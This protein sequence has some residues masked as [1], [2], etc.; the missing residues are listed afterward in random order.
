MG[1]GVCRD[2]EGGMGEGRAGDE[3]MA[4]E[5]WEGVVGTLT[6]IGCMGLADNMVDG[7][8]R[9]S[10]DDGGDVD[11]SRKDDGEKGRGGSRLWRADENG[12]ID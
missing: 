1:E 6:G 2:I 11:G 8:E 7:D 12:I 3:G 9:G 5:R 10:F 4:G